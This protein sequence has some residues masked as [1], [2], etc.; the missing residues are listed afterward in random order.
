MMDHPEAW[1]KTGAY[2]AGNA[3]YTSG[4]NADNYKIGLYPV[5]FPSQDAGKQAVRTERQLELAWKANVSL[6]L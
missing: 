2:D 1:V 4:S 3:I 5:P 6:I